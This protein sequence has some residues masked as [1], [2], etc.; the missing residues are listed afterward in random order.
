MNINR[1]TFIRGITGAAALTCIPTLAGSTLNALDVV[2]N[3]NCVSKT[4]VKDIIDFA[5][6][7]VIFQNTTI[8]FNAAVK[9]YLRNLSSKGF[10]MCKK[11][12]Q[13]GITTA[14][15]VYAIWRAKYF[16]NQH[17]YIVE[18]KYDLCYSVL[19]MI[20]KICYNM[21]M[22]GNLDSYIG[23]KGKTIEFA[24]GNSIT[25]CSDS[26]L[27]NIDFDI[28]E[29]TIILD[30][31][32][33]MQKQNLKNILG[34]IMSGVSMKNT[35]FYI[36][37]TPYQSDD[38]F[39]LFYLNTSDDNKT[40]ITCHDAFDSETVDRIKTALSED[41]FNTDMLCKV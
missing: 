8:K 32:A 9:D 36:S 33:F 3:S 7:D 28:N 38:I 6:H 16:E 11:C 27:H 2:K 31:I 18:P 23:F 15:G 37:S 20:N 41:S 22:H 35:N 4:H 26:D 1:R 34:R 25:V 21:N 24:D 10:F 40:T 39:S 13:A 5:E 17:I 12:R 19:H 14:N 29:T 30:E